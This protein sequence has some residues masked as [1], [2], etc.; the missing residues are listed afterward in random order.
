LSR[1]IAQI[2]IMGGAPTNYIPGLLAVRGPLTSKMV[3]SRSLPVTD[4]S[5]TVLG[6]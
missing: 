2:T 1:R 3:A 4:A 6:R 5:Y